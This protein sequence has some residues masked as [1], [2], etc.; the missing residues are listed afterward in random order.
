MHFFR[1]AL[2][3]VENDLPRSTDFKRYTQYEFLTYDYSAC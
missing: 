1:T 3:A 2:F